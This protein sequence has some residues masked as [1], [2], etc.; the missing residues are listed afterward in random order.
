MGMKVSST[1]TWGIPVTEE[2]F[3]WL[4]TDDVDGIYQP[5]LRC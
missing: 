5:F 3:E 4:S 2:T 1:G